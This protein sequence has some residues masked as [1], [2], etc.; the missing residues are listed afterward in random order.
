MNQEK[1]INEL[2]EC[3]KILYEFFKQKRILTNLHK[4]IIIKSN[5]GD[6]FLVR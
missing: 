3:I 1:Q 6:Y 5:N 4:Y 2:C